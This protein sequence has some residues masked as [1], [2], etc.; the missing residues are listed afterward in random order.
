[1]QHDLG[2]YNHASEIKF[3]HKIKILTIE[4]SCLTIYTVQSKN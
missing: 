1:M 2:T 4:I 3:S